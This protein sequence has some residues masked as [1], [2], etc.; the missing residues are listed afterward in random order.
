VSPSWLLDRGI[1]YTPYDKTAPPEVT[2]PNTAW[3]SYSFGEPQGSGELLIR[4]GT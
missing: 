4:F 1:I 2:P 3:H